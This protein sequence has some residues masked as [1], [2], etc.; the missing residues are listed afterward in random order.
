MGSRPSLLV[1]GSEAATI[2]M[3]GKWVES[4]RKN[5]GPAGEPLLCIAFRYIGE[6][7]KDGVMQRPS[8]SSPADVA[9]NPANCGFEGFDAIELNPNDL[10]NSGS[11]DEFDLATFAGRIENPHTIAPN[12]GAPNTDLGREFVSRRAASAL[13][14]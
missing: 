1:P 2:L 3:A 5:G 10:T 9:R 13:R 7:L 8:E 12:A 6:P 11:F 4:G 14:A